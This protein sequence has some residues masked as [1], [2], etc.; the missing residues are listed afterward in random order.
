VRNV[1]LRARGSTTWV[2]DDFLIVAQ[3]M[4]N[5]DSFQS[6]RFV[7]TLK[8]GEKVENLTF[9]LTITKFDTNQKKQFDLDLTYNGDEE[10]KAALQIYFRKRNGDPYMKKGNCDFSCVEEFETVY[11]DS[12][13]GFEEYFNLED[14][15]EDLLVDGK[16]TIVCNLIICHKGN[17]ISKTVGQD[18][19]EEEETEPSVESALLSLLQD[20]QDNNLSDVQLKCEDRTFNCHK[21]ILKARSDVFAAMF[22]FKKASGDAAQSVDMNDTDPD[23]LDNLI[24]YIYGNKCDIEAGNARDLLALAE[25][26]NVK[27]LKTRCEVFLRGTIS[28]ENV[29][30]LHGLSLTH[31]AKKLLRDVHNFVLGN[32]NRLEKALKKRLLKM[33]GELWDKS[34]SLTSE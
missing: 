15:T 13:F 19:V 7:V 22:R 28:I 31:N 23:V 9:I 17:N 25:K 21:A 16:V 30:S 24:Q 1:Q 20:V 11:P 27:G 26:Y 32:W 5:E 33:D 2:I 12:S 8:N 10:I 29:E 6:P 14:I 18:S 34:L 3:A 4:K